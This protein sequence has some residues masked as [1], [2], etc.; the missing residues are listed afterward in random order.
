MSEGFIAEAQVLV[1]PNTK[2]FREEILALRA[3][4]SKPI[5]VPVT[6][7]TA[8][9][10][11]GVAN[12]TGATAGLT[13]SQRNLQQTMQQTSGVLKT[14]ALA[15][16]NSTAS[17]L[18]A[19]SATGRLDAALLGLRTAVGSSAVIGLGALSLAAIA[20]GAAIRASLV[21]FASFQQ[22]LATFRVTAGAS[23]E[24]MK[25]VSDAAVQLGADVKL[26]AVSSADAAVAMTELAKAGL[27]VQDSIE[28]ARGVLELATA[29]QLSNADAALITANAL[30]SFGLAGTE[31]T[32]V[33]DDFANAANAAQGSIADI[34][35][36]FRQ[37]SAVARQVGLSLEDTT[38]ILSLFA[39]NG[40]QGSD[41]GTSLRVALI[42][43]VAP[44]KQAAAE[45]KTLGLNIRDAAGNVRADV[46]AQFGEATRKLT[47]AARDAAAALIFGQ[48]AIRAVA[49]GAR[50]GTDGLR[51]MQFQIDRQGTAAEVAAARTEG[52]AGQFSALASNMQTLSVNFG[53]LL[54]LPLV[55]FLTAINTAVAD[56]NKLTET[57][58]GL[59]NI[60]IPPIHIPFVFDFPGGDVPG[61]GIPKTVANAV[62]KRFEG[63]IPVVG[64]ALQLTG[65]VDDLRKL[66]GGADK[67]AARVAR[68]RA[69][70]QQLQDVR[71]LAQA[72]GDAATADRL[73]ARIEALKKEIKALEN[74]GKNIPDA[75]TS[76]LGKAI[77]TL[78]A[79]KTSAG[80]GDSRFLD[81]MILA[82]QRAANEAGQATI[83]INDLPDGITR[84]GVTARTAADGV[85]ALAAAMSRLT[86][87]STVL[88]DQLQKAQAEGASPQTQIGILQQQNA[89][90]RDII[91]QAEKGG[92]TSGDITTIRKARAIII[93]N[94]AK[95]K[96]L[97]DGIASDRK[98]AATSAQKAADD[99][100][101]Q[102]DKQFT[103][104]ADLFGGRQQNIEDA[105]ARAGINGNVARE[106]KLNQALIASAKKEIAT[107][108][109]R[110][111][112][113]K[114][115]AAVRKAIF[116]AIN[117]VI[118]QA[119][120]DQI[121]LQQDL[122]DNLLKVFDFR[123]SLA[124]ARD[125][126]VA[127]LKAR[128]QRLSAIT[129][130]LA[131][132]KN[133]HKKNTDRWRELKLA[134]AEEIA[135]INDLEG[136]TKE[137][138]NAQK[139]LFFTFLQTQQGFA[140]NLL[141]NLIP[142]FA[143]K[144]LVGGST[145]DAGQA[146]FQTQ[147][148]VA[149]EAAVATSRERGV[150][151]VQVDTTNHLLRQILHSLQN[152]N[153]RQS[154]PEARYQR[155]VASGGMDT[156]E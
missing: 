152:L 37:A 44:T 113:I 84:V 109:E 131:R 119:Q 15:A 148:R 111:K 11:V 16:K 76:N 31:A 19:A 70:M 35:L 53:N 94:N 104:L 135:A 22:E 13:A 82:L 133:A 150:R 91:A 97:Q 118:E 130:E 66:A 151:P 143:T 87:Q 128:R 125:D 23:A 127:E 98:A 114:I 108:K 59:G 28:G 146:A 25:N 124:Q 24:E 64:P 79:L 10:A 68:L 129:A 47:P 77:T 153:G 62:A 81:R 126:T 71:I 12:L 2:L 57:I 140:A 155:S 20:A 122:Q 86:Q 137:K 14:Q 3:Q 123:V 75:L 149:Q 30:N 67:T 142:G 61:G 50:E 115:S 18:G 34:G 138:N 69:E 154:S 8:G 1:V 120:Q 99:A 58:K 121:R 6:T 83:K 156:V 26:P 45:I 46:F 102:R 5:V 116:D 106:I 80:S 144:G 139:S 78:E 110:F 73:T 96:S 36:A 48:D 38:A 141:G 33:A 60:K 7:V 103:A 63:I 43:L 145:P 17:L 27:S 54:S 112:H 90:Q 100:Q 21:N 42:R 4:L 32:R 92:R 40:L 49:I 136:K 132:L 105:I 51:L 117:R 72:G 95:I 74:E 29:A 55:P 107:L 65:I 41:A 93:A 39:K 134:Q 9:G 88:S 89:T 52:L 101:T 85:D 56:L 147:P